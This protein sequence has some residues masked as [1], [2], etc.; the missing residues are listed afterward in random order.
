M[1]A[2]QKGTL[3]FLL[4]LLGLFVFVSIS[5]AL[6]L[7]VNT[8]TNMLLPGEE[9]KVSVSCRDE[10][11]E[12]K[13][14]NRIMRVR[15]SR[16]GLLE[17]EYLDEGLYLTEGKA[18]FTYLAPEKLGRAE[19][20]LIDLKTN[21]TIKKSLFVVN[22]EQLKRQTRQEYAEV[23]EFIGK[24]L[25]KHKGKD[26]WDTV[27]I[28]QKLYRGDNIKTWG[29]SWVKLTLF[30]G[31]EIT[32]EPNTEF[33]INKLNSSLDNSRIKEGVFQ[34]IIGTVINNI[35]DFSGRGSRFR[36][37]TE[38]AVAGVRGTFFEVTYREGKNRVRV[39]EGSVRTEHKEL[40]RTYVVN[41]GEEITIDREAVDPSGEIKIP[42]IEKHKVEKKQKMKEIKKKKVEDK[43]IL[44]INEDTDGHPSENASDTARDKAS[45][46]SIIGTGDSDDVDEDNDGDNDNEDN[47][48]D[49]DNEDD[50]NDN[51]NEDN[52]IDEDEDTDGHPGEHA[53]DTA[54]DKASEKS[55]IGK[56]YN[57]DGY[58]IFLLK[59]FKYFYLN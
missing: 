54:K 35:R 43:K 23:S 22:K 4:V 38:S 33:E 56:N 36:I 1:K 16:G 42:V 31:S 58:Y 14:D 46:N 45:E 49:N 57:N 17:S 26:T 12:L 19:I 29:H 18:E 48:G 9:I 59:D 52:D 11:G 53:S 55:I 40:A 32:L 7:E 50:D 10:N 6:N 39:Y 8:S 27:I 37:E 28:G 51:D 13:T 30:D 15:V 2:L 25:V 20:L 5:S 21:E 24:A 44:G 34:L 47:D 41:K 3:S